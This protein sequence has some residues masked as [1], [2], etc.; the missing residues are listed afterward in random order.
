[1]K[2]LRKI[3]KWI[4]CIVLIPISYLIVSLILSLITIDRKVEN[5]VLDKTI[6][7]NTNGIHLDIVLPKDNVDSLLL[8][9]L[10]QEDEDDFFS[11]GWGDENFYINTPTW[12]DLTAKTALKAMFLKSPTL[13]HVTRYESTQ[14]DWIEIKISD[15]ELDLLNAY[16]IQTFKLDDNGKIIILE[17]QGYTSIDDFYKAN[18][19]Y[20]CFNTCNS[21]VNTGFKKSGLTACAWTPFDFVLM[22]KHD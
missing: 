3:L 10:K 14:N 6:Y 18:G 8:S 17:D 1:M 21:W 16:L 12:G 22:K 13:M 20:N 7:L 11:F 9:G 2:L 5:Q 15:S 19:N 4:F